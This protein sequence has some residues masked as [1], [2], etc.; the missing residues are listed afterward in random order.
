MVYAS[1]TKVSSVD[2]NK[3]DEKIAENFEL[4]A[5]VFRSNGDSDTGVGLWRRLMNTD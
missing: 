5:N 3:L 4:V 1:M 2:E